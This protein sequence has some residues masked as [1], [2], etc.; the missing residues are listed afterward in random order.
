MAAVSLQEFLDQVRNDLEQV[1]REKREIG[2]LVEQSKAEVDRLV[3]RQGTVMNQLRQV[4][5]HFDTV[6][7][8]DIKQTYDSALDT[9]Q[10]LFSMRGQL[11]K[12]QSEQNSL[13]R[14]GRT[15]QSVLEVLGEVSPVDLLAGPGSAANGGGAESEPLVLRIIEAQETE[16]QRMSKAMHDGPAQ[17]L[18]NFIL[19]AEIIQRLFENNPDQ[20]KLELQ[21]LKQ[22][23]TSTFQRVREFI[24]E[25]RPMM[26][27]DLGL[28]PTVRRYVKGFEE[29]TGSQ[30]QLTITGQETTRFEP[31]REVLAFRALQ[32]LL[33][34]IREHA[35]CTQV[36]VTIDVG[37]THVRASV[38]DNGKGFDVAAI[39]AQEDE[40]HLG[41]RTLKERVELLGGNLEVESTPGQ[42]TRVGV[43]LPV[44][45]VNALV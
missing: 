45:R 7:R 24:T 29:K 31:H 35:E 2:M 5:Q 25:L 32:E 36:R 27:D 9:Q 16:R 18:T 8:G 17:S 43:E 3:Q 21:N 12:L 10:K 30:V 1:E 19:Q 20:A 15:L 38:E 44:G 41:L 6:P 40:H 11:E 26:L 34:N 33:T 23:A 14:F 28:V 37:E 4:Q 13:D 42:G 39:L 22:A